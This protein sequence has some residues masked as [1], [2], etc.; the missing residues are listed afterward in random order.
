M[1]K[2]LLTYDPK[3]A[4]TGFVHMGLFSSFASDID[5]KIA[6][7]LAEDAEVSTLSLNRGTANTVWPKHK[8][9]NPA[10]PVSTANPLSDP[11]EMDEL[12]ERLERS[13]DEADLVFHDGFSLLAQHMNL[14]DISAKD[15]RIRADF[16]RFE[17]KVRELETVLYKH[18]EKLHSIPK[19]KG[20]SPADKAFTEGSM[21]GNGVVT[22]RTW[23]V[24]E[25]LS[26]PKYPAVLK[27]RSGSMGDFVF[28]VSG[29]EDMSKYFAG[30]E[31]LFDIFHSSSG[32]Y[33]RSLKKEI[34]KKGEYVVQEHIES[35]GDHDSHFRVF[36][37]KDGSVLCAVL[38]V[39]P[40][41][42][43]KRM[44]E[45]ICTKKWGQTPSLE[46]GLGKRYM[47][48]YKPVSNSSQG[49]RQIALAG[50]PM[51]LD[52]WNEISNPKYMDIP[53]ILEA[54]GIDPLNPKLPEDLEERAVEAARVLGE[55]GIAY[56]GQD[57][58]T[59][60]EGNRYFLEM[61]PTPGFEAFNTVYAGDFENS[62]DFGIRKVAEALRNTL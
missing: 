9:G 13:V 58:I 11:A 7:Y 48:L 34:P 54:H 23:T 17:K 53:S 12:K 44:W 2:V 15:S 36:T 29:P 22:P 19:T 47:W 10:G 45:E 3:W 5:T 38:S 62:V 35:P 31:L 30:K 55:H 20:I 46:F 42:K 59:D 25:F 43:D 8:D 57:W 61:N 24:E 26:S 52:E 51:T 18:P 32:G 40:R 16:Y 28:L 41:T 27:K 49:G 14:I 33:S 6:G 4:N 37:V 39:S 1:A 50:A 21:N 60:S 56:G